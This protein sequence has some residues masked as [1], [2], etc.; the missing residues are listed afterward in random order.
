MRDL[1]RGDETDRHPQT[2]HEQILAHHRTQHK[3]QHTCRRP[4]TDRLAEPPFQAP[5]IHSDHPFLPQNMHG[6]NI[7]SA[8]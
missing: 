6:K 8:K 7:C 3:K 2:E 4:H 5:F 1:I